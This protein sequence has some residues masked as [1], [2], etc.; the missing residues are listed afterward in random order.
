MNEKIIFWIRD[1]VNSYKKLKKTE[2]DWRE[3]IIGFASANDPL[4][5]KL[6]ELVSP[7]HALPSDF[8]CDAE[9]VIV[10]FLPF[11][12]NIVNSNIRGI[13]SSREWDIANIETNNLILDINKFLFEK[14]T[15]LGYTSS[16]LP[17]TY[18]YDEKMLVSDWSHRHIGYIAGV[19]TFG[20][21]NMLITDS[22]CCGRMG[23]I[24][25]NLPLNPSL[26]QDQENCLYKYNGTCQKCINRCV[27]NAISTA[28]GYPFLEKRKCSDQIYND[29]V[30]EYPIG[31]GD[32]CGKCMC[33]VP[34]SLINPANLAK[35]L[36]RL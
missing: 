5:Y 15:A 11:M 23:S 20:I 3:P 33:N 32:A 27:V 26:R 36:K 29:N 14:I 19:G 24:I 18:N 35:K 12:E 4:F 8:I 9:S 10:F 21:N 28:N 6:K 7:S 34:C 1:Y 17:P 2:S 31:L 30:P 16:V 13:E 22:G 25:T